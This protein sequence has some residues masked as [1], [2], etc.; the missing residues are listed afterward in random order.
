MK[1]GDAELLGTFEQ[2]SPEWHEARA[3]MI[4]GSD[5]ASVLGLSH[6]KSGY[7]L[8]HE[9]AGLVE[10]R[11][12]D[13]NGRRKLAYGH[14]MEP[15]IAAEFVSRHPDLVVQETG[16]WRNIE[17]PWQGC[18]PDRLLSFEGKDAHSLL[19]IKT[20]NYP[21]DWEDGAPVGYLAQVRWEMDT[22]GFERGWLAVYFN[23]GGG[24]AEFEIEADAFE[25]DAVRARARAFADSL[26]EGEPPAID[27]SADTYRTIRKLNPSLVRGREVEIDR[28]L[29]QNY[30][31]A[32]AGYKTAESDV[33][34]WRGH[35]LAHMG[36]AQYAVHDGR[37]IAS[38][39]AVKDGVPF[40][41]EA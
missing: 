13:E 16:T 9:K 3:G 30:R 18:N 12:P 35:L 17:R 11:E 31:G 19:Q 39:V 37:R 1:I 26:T 23:V 33:N 32:V 4:G 24:Y 15:F 21:A 14:H 27:G 25:A 22:F 34:K 7:T 40:L 38:R 10:P 2:D 20:A 41:K 29:A 28:D 36:T 8:W 5:I 6:F